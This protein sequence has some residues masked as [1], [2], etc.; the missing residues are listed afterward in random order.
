MN[1]GGVLTKA[2]MLWDVRQG[3]RD[4]K[5]QG[6]YLDSPEGLLR[7]EKG[8]GMHSVSSPNGC[9]IVDSVLRGDPYANSSQIYTWLVIDICEPKT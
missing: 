6:L 9:R 7:I 2:G 4:W 5:K 1:A 3:Y 8:S